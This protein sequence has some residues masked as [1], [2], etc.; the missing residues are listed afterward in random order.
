[1]LPARLRLSSLLSP[2][3][4][5]SY[6]GRVRSGFTKSSLEWPFAITCLAYDSMPQR[7]AVPQRLLSRPADKPAE[8]ERFYF[9]LNTNRAVRRHVVTE[10]A[11]AT[12]GL[13]KCKHY[14]RLRDQ[15]GERRHDVTILT[16]VAGGR[17]RIE[18]G[19][20]AGMDKSTLCFPQAAET[21]DWV[22]F[23]SEPLVPSRRL[24]H[25]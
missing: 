5:L 19:L 4:W 15:Q 3:I 12:Q 2:P 16:A 1:M 21:S 8:Q 14:H 23:H 18:V 6:M 24:S 9:H 20:R 22:D 25:W 11:L 13:I 7:T 10:R 17:G